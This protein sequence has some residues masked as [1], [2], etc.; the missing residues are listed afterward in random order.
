[1]DYKE[2]LIDSQ[3]SGMGAFLK[4]V[5]EYHKYSNVLANFVEGQ[6]YSYYIGRIENKSGYKIDDILCFP[7]NGRTEVE[8]VRFMLSNPTLRISSDIKLLFYADRDYDIKEK[9]EDIFYT[10]YYS[11]ENFYCSETV[12]NRILN[13]VFNINKFMSDYNICIDL[14]KEKLK[15]YRDTI[16]RVNAFCYC[17]RKKEYENSLDRCEFGSIRFKRFVEDDNFDNFKM[18]SLSIEDLN[19]IFKPEIKII[20]SELDDAL[21]LIDETKYRGKWEL[22]FLCWFLNELKG[23]INEGTHNLEKNKRI[24][25]DFNSQPLII[26]SEYADD[27]KTLNEY[28]EQRIS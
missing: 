14:Y 6:D 3:G 9:N 8:K 13:K 7:C 17:V 4:F 5:L 16:K 20:E 11:V 26:L 25:L 24:R 2:F 19:K 27:S 21:C 1:M 10:D 22:G 15:I 23:C 28:I 18:K 12:L